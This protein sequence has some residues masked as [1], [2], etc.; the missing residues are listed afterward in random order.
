MGTA[1]H[2]ALEKIYEPVLNQ[3]LTATYLKKILNDKELI[4]SLVRE[5]LSTRF[6]EQSLRQ[7]KNYL[8]Y[9]ICQSLVIKLP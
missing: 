1:V 7:G 8:L 9:N 2:Y 4:N 6:E 5:S 3:V